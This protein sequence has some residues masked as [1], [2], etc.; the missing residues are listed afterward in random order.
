MRTPAPI[1]VRTVS[2]VCAVLG[3]RGCIGGFNGSLPWATCLGFLSNDPVRQLRD[4]N[5]KQFLASKLSPRMQH[6][7]VDARAAEEGGRA[8]AHLA[9]WLGI[10]RTAA[11]GDTAGEGAAPTPSRRAP[12][13][14][15]A[16]AAPPATAA[17]PPA[18]PP[19]AAA[20]PP[21]AAA[22]IPPELQ[23]ALDAAKAAFQGLNKSELTELCAF[24]NP[25]RL[26]VQV[27][28]CCQIVVGHDT[29]GWASGRTWLRRSLDELLHFDTDRLIR[30]KTYRQ[31]VDK[32]VGELPPQEEIRRMSVA[33]TGLAGWCRGIVCAVSW[34]H[35]R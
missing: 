33:A 20:T 14:A 3:V 17:A 16:A 27:V 21:A 23:V 34:R 6:I 1:V 5:A 26:V 9:A 35:H 4:F 8:V 11:I 15:P 28:D 25:P 13:P 18:T 12:A 2:G 32:A 29:Q 10:L 30:D 19:A 24:A 31:R 22:A 7:D